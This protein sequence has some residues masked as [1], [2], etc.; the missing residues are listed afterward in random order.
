MSC[1]HSQGGWTALQKDSHSA[2]YTQN[3]GGQSHWTECT[4]WTIFTD[5]HTDLQGRARE[6]EEVGGR[7]KERQK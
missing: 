5:V 3:I 4:E 1:S 2:L 7:G 6:K